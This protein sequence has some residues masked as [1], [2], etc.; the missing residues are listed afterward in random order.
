M[1]SAGSTLSAMRMATMLA[2]TQITSKKKKN[3][4]WNPTASAGHI[5]ETGAL[6]SGCDLA[7]HETNHAQGERLLH[8]HRGDGS[9]AC[10]DELQHRDL[11]DFVHRQRIDDE[12]NDGRANDGQN[13]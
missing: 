7:D 4:R 10:A 1:A 2:R 8:D 12:G 13:H 6:K 9:V 5:W 11:A 3:R